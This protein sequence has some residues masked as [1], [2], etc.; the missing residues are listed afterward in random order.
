VS[1]LGL[2]IKREYLERVRSKWFI[3][4]TLLGPLLMA[5]LILAPAMA[6][7]Y[8]SPQQRI[9]ILDASSTPNLAPTITAK[10]E[11]RKINS[12]QIEQRTVMDD[13]ELKQAQTQLNDEIRRE[14][15]SGYLLLPRNCLETGEVEYFSQNVSDFIGL[16][17]MESAT[18]SAI[19]ELRLANVGLDDEKVAQLTKPTEMKR[20]KLSDK[21]SQEDKG[22]N[23]V[24]AYILMMIIYTSTVLYGTT[25]MRG[26]IEEKQSRIVEVIISSVSPMQLM[27]GKVLGIGLVGLTQFSIW[28]LFAAILPT[29]LAGLAVTAGFNLPGM[30]ISLI[31]YF[32]LFFILG[33]FL[34]ATLYVIVGS[35]VSNEQD[36]NQAQLPVVMLLIF[37]IVFAS[38]ILRDPNGQVATILSLIPFF[39]PI[40]MFLRITVLTPPFWQ[41]LTSLLILVATILGSVWLAGR[42]YR[43]G[44]LMYGK[45]ATPKEVLKWLRYT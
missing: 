34:Y 6:V 16:N 43:V 22:Q 10:L 2:I 12:F 39:A 7:R 1:K 36:A 32:V 42:I 30:P 28:G 15:L 11:K 25:V 24:L 8:V 35:I 41:I 9:I 3:I 33:Y 4:G 29:V 13:G 5:G 17:L 44:I 19:L 26:V 20:N 38:V 14:K 45:R 40:L 23:F 27:F 31:I 21:G 18:N 37:A